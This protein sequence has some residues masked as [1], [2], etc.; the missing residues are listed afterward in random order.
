MERIGPLLGRVAA[1]LVAGVGLALLATGCVADDEGTVSLG[2]GSPGETTLPPLTQPANPETITPTSSASGSATPP[3]DSTTP[4]ATERLAPLEGLDA[5]LVADGFHQP[6][7]VTSAPGTSALFVVEREGRV[8]IVDDGEV[9]EEP[10]LDL[11]S[12]LTSSSIEQG[13]LGLAFHPGYETNG[14]FFAYWTAPNGDSRLAE[15]HASE[16]TVAE[17]DS[18]A[19]ILEVP[20]P[21]ERHNAGMLAFG[22]DGLLYVAL[23]DGG[24][25]GSTAQDTSNL[26]GS[27][28]RLAVDQPGSYTV[29]P[30]NPFDDEIWVYGLRNPWRFWIDPADELIYIGDVGQEAFEEI[31]IIGLDDGGTNFGWFEMEGDTCFRGECDETGKTPPALQYSHAE[32]CSVTGG[33]VY[34]GRA[35]PEFTG[36]YFFADWCKSLLRSLRYDGSGIRD[37]F[38]WTSELAELGQ[39]TSFGVDASGELLTVNWDGQLHRIVPRR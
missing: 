3:S 16:P 1:T 35:I 18:L 13:L 9:A 2:T 38:D 37:Q 29:P 32:G 25:G 10:F 11:R 8:L 36:H 39:V 20:Q 23:G 30:D 7:Y 28:L 12:E 21:A 26:L 27:I 33:I 34:R 22:P 24:S 4:S 14:R 31:N 19:V 17:P 6:I 15:F 5:E